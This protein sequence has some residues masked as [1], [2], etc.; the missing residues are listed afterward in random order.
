MEGTGTLVERPYLIQFDENNHAAIKA[1]IDPYDMQQ[2]LCK[3]ITYSIDGQNITLY[4]DEKPIATVTNQTKDM[5]EFYD[6]P[7]WIGEQ[8]EYQVGK[9]LTVC[10]VPG[11]SFVTGKVLIYDDMPTI[12]ADVELTADG[13]NLSDFRVLQ[14]N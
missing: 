9:K 2:E 1:S 6:D 3:R 13:F 12:A 5:G 7:I 10:F 11:I 4:A 8:I 14:E